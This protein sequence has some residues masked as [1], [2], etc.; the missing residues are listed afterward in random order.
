MEMTKCA[1]QLSKLTCGVRANINLY[2]NIRMSVSLGLF[3]SWQNIYK[4]TEPV[5]IHNSSTFCIHLQICI[6]WIVKWPPVPD[7]HKRSF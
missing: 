4:S 7:L 1:C 6:L 3:G 2:Y 5:A